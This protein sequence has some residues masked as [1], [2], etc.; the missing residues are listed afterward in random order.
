MLPIGMWGIVCLN[1][2]AYFSQGDDGA[3]CLVHFD[4][5]SA[6]LLG[7]EVERRTMPEHV[8]QASLTEHLERAL[9]GASVNDT[10]KVQL[11][12][13]PGMIER[14]LTLARGDTTVLADLK[15]PLL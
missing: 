14:L 15:S 4:H 8:T 3:Q 13:Q 11:L 12:R 9:R 2:G 1:V 6:L 7:E 5:L 10:L